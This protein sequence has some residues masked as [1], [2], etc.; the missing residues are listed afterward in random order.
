M[1]CVELDRS[2]C[3]DT[4]KINIKNFILIPIFH[5]IIMMEHRV[6]LRIIG[7]SELL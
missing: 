4:L 1:V 6:E 2:A 5:L 3:I 7:R